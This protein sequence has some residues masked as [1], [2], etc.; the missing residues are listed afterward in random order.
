MLPPTSGLR[1]SPRLL[2]MPPSKQQK[3]ASWMPL[4]IPPLPWDD[5][6]SPGS[7]T[8]NFWPWLNVIHHRRCHCHLPHHCPYP[9]P[10]PSLRSLLGPLYLVKMV[11][12]HCPLLTWKMQLRTTITRTLMGSHLTWSMSC[13][14]KQ[15]EWTYFEYFVDTM[16]SFLM[17]TTLFPIHLTCV[18]I[19]YDFKP[20]EAKQELTNKITLNHDIQSMYSR[21]FR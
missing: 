5:A 6:S 3:T 20:I 8:S 19:W 11:T 16:F 14:S 10:Y 2:P 12:H 15:N 4:R 18:R 7:S 1:P 17:W 21:P 13:H 9:C